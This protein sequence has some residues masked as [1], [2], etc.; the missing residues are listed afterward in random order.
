MCGGA[1]VSI[2]KT[3]LKLTAS[4][5]SHHSFIPGRIA[6]I[7]IKGK[8]IGIMGEIHPYVLNNFDIEM[9]VALLEL[10]IE[11]LLGILEGK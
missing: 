7:R 1:S 9:P 4:E 10:N 6:S 2:D 11:Q 8:S 5:Y 3:V